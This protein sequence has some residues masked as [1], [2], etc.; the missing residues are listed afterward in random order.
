MTAK[1]KQTGTAIEICSLYR[2]PTFSSINVERSVLRLDKALTSC[3]LNSSVS[4]YDGIY[5]KIQQPINCSFTSLQANM[6]ALGST[7][8]LVGLDDSMVGSV[9][10][11]TNL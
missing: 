4:N 8:A 10:N 2:G 11:F 7:L 1:N 6:I 3:D 9:K 5:F